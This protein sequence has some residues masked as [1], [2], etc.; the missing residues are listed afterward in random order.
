MLP[1]ARNEPYDAY[2]DISFFRGDFCHENRIE[3][4]PK[5]D[6]QTSQNEVRILPLLVTDDIEAAL[7]ARSYDRIRQLALALSAVFKGVGVK[8]NLESMNEQ[9]QSVTGRD[10]NSAFTL[11]RTSH[12]TLRVRFGA[13]N[14][15]MARYSMIPQTHNVTLLLMVPKAM[16]EEKEVHG[17]T[18]RMVSRTAIVDAQ[19]GKELDDKYSKYG[20]DEVLK[21]L[22]VRGIEKPVPPGELYSLQRYVAANDYAEFRK[23]VEDKLQKYVNQDLKRPEDSIRKLALG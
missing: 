16:L 18:V 10:Y 23:Y 7:E 1:W 6:G 2:A 3:E 22:A 14:Q 21:V 17:K 11:A 20:P 5:C 15:A 19:D 9:L 8:S 4:T 13:V 12:N